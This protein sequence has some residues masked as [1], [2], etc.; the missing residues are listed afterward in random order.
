MS[1]VG[2]DVAC[3]VVVNDQ[4]QY[5]VW[6]A[7]RKLPAGWRVESGAGPDRTGKTTHF[8]GRQARRSRHMR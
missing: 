5:S 1:D 4:H 7:Q 6:P 8:L 3:L 2:A